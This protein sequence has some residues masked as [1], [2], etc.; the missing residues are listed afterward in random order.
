[1]TH[2]HGDILKTFPAIANLYREKH[3]WTLACRAAHVD[4][5]INAHL[6]MQQPCLINVARFGEKHKRSGIILVKGHSYWSRIGLH[7][8]FFF[9][10]NA[11]NITWTQSSLVDSALSLA[12]ELPYALG[13][14]KGKKKIYIYIPPKLKKQTNTPWPQAPE[15]IRNISHAT[16]LELFF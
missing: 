4:E 2:L 8:F 16:F 12:W 1:M 15:I 3:F 11:I 13:M 5:Q 9:F 7:S 6:Q 14:D 10:N